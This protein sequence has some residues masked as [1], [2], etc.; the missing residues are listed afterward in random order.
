MS[1]RAPGTVALKLERQRIE[2]GWRQLATKLAEAALQAKLVGLNPAN[3]GNALT[4]VFGAADAIRVEET[5][6]T[7]AWHLI[8]GALQRATL[9]LL[10]TTIS[11]RQPPA[12]DLAHFENRIA[13]ALGDGEVEID[14]DFLRRPLSLPVYLPIRRSF[15]DLLV[16]IGLAEPEARLLGQRLDSYFPAALYAE[17]QALPGR[18]AP[19]VQAL[20]GGP[21]LDAARQAWEWDCNHRALVRAMDEPLFDESFGLAAVYIPLRAWHAVAAE[22]E[23]PERTRADANRR[24]EPERIVIDLAEHTLTWLA[25]PKGKSDTIRLITGGP[26][27]GK[28][29]FVK[30]LAAR[31]AR[32]ALGEEVWPGSGTLPS[33]VLFVPLQSIYK[34]R[35]IEEL[36]YDYFTADLFTTDP[37]EFKHL[38]PNRTLVILDGLDELSKAADIAAAQTEAFVGELR[39]TL[40]HV[41]NRDGTVRVLAL[42]TGRPAAMQAQGRMLRRDPSQELYV[43]P[44]YLPDL[45]SHGYVDPDQ[46]L[47][48]DHRPDWWA[49]YAAAKG[50]PAAMPA[51]LKLKE[52]DDLTAEPLTSFLV[53]KSG[54]DADYEAGRPV[55][56]NEVYARLVNQVLT[57]VHGSRPLAAVED[58]GDADRFHLVMEVIATAAWYGDGRTASLADVERCCPPDLKPVLD[59]YLGQNQGLARLVTAFH[60]KLRDPTLPRDP[61][62]EFTHKSFAEYLTARRLVREVES[63]HDALT[64]PQSRYTAENGLTD[65]LQLTGPQAI[66]ADLLRFLRDEV[67]LRPDETITAWLPSLVCL[68]KANLADGM[69]AHM[70]ATTFRDAERRARNAE[71]AVL[72]VLNACARVWEAPVVI[73]GFHETARALVQGRLTIVGRRCLSRLD[74]SRADL[75]KANLSEADLSGADLRGA[76]LGGADLRG[77]DLGGADLRGADLGGAD[78]R[79]AELGGADLGEADLRGADL[80]EADLRRADLREANLGGAD[81]GEAYLRGADLR[82]ADLHGAD[83]RAVVLGSPSSLTE[84][85]RTSARYRPEDPL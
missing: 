49:R 22:P 37:L 26:G 15:E 1:D 51:V 75:S 85:Q 13:L 21:L 58:V 39:N 73:E 70:K 20:H 63:I 82:G 62:I 83:L 66:T 17:E 57:R 3:L 27:S 78:L 81:L 38:G 84:T 24:T 23:P 31:L 40:D 56:R 59:R 11:D 76:D 68:F 9:E 45:D 36:L 77:A 60:F 42:V 6:G 65:W 35:P 34:N 2:V 71:E 14:R 50:R 64:T 16:R 12:G 25:Y 55:N 69:P 46:R 54:Y 79:G 53:V 18:Y 80:R 29:S 8:E 41:W 61:G 7:I 19:L 67:A 30:W 4:A 74:F 52:L 5:S 28:S 10:G 47:H 48:A 43:L 33:R 72:A 44:Y 32:G